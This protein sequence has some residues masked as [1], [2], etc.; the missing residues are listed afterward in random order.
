MSVLIPDLVTSRL[1]DVY[2]TAL[3]YHQTASVLPCLVASCHASDLHIINFPR[4]ACLGL[5]VTL[6]LS[7]IEQMAR[8]ACVKIFFFNGILR[9]ITSSMDN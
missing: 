9:Q 7:N 5:R 3:M 6:H 1:F 2:L 4:L 8:A